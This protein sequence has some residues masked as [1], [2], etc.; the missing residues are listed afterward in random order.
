MVTAPWR[1]VGSGFAS[2]AVENVI[3]TPAIV[4]PEIEEAVEPLKVIQGTS[5]EIV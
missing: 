3:A 5:A 2:I 1:G 4:V